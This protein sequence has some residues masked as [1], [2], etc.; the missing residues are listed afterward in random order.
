MKIV[1]VRERDEHG[2]CFCLRV[3]P[4]EDNM[5]GGNEFIESYLP[6]EGNMVEG[7]ELSQ[8]FVRR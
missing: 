1:D 8:L 4:F 6:C 7:N 3:H 5:V 2:V